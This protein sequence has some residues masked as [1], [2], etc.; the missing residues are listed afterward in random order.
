VR[1]VAIDW[2]G[3]KR[4]AGKKI[5]AAEFCDGEPVE[6]LITGK[7]RESLK[8]CLVDAASKSDRLIVG[9]DFAFSFPSWFVETQASSVQG[10]WTKVSHQG[11]RWLEECSWPFWG[12]K[13]R[14]R[15]DLAGNSHYRRTEECIGKIAGISPKSVFQ[16]NG[17]GAVGTGSI[18]GMAILHQLSSQFR[19]WPF[20]EAGWPKII[21][22]WPRLLTGKVRKS[23]RRER[24]QFVSEKYRWIPS[25]WQ[26]E[27]AKSEDAFDAIVSACVMQQNQD[28]LSHLDTADDP[29]TRL[30][31]LIWCPP[32]ANNRYSASS[33]GGR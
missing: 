4:G 31:G 12:R 30:E 26:E 29:I 33:S 20:D 2:S 10:L 1:I 14:T 27:A 28:V 13:G 18:R 32:D 17:G 15:C 11:E 7:D 3:A 19:I 8:D 24:E 9:L 21:E 25:R 6:E 23:D 16:I 5:W 22:I